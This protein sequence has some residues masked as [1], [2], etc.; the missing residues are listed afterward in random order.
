MAL[1]F[2]WAP[3]RRMRWSHFTA[4]DTEV[5]REVNK[6]GRVP[7]HCSLVAVSHQGGRGLLCHTFPGSLYNHDSSAGKRVPYSFTYKESVIWGPEVIG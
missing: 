2:R 3:T 4:G 1:P 6:G 7:Q 5:E